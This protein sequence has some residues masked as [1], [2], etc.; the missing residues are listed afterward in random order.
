MA[1]ATIKGRS[2]SGTG[3]PEDLSASQVRTILNVAD[4]ANAYTHPNHTGDVTSTGDGATAIAANAVT[5]SKLAQIATATVKA[6]TS[7]STGN[8]EDVSFADLA[9]R[10]GDAQTLR[11]GTNQSFTSTTFAVLLDWDDT[12]L[13]PDWVTYDG[14][15]GEFTIV[16]NAMVKL[17][18]TI[19]LVLNA[20]GNAAFQVEV[21]VKTAPS[22]YSRLNDFLTTQDVATTRDGGANAPLHVAWAARAGNVFVL[23]G[24]RASGAAQINTKLAWTWLTIDTRL[25]P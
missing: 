14:A 23:R 9:A 21:A 4:G 20:V 10:L 13:D 7:A 25:I 8:V 12:R 16:Q 6:R 22:T 1:N 2:T 15:T 18:A 3:D 24:R 19:A 11:L 5:N 17:D